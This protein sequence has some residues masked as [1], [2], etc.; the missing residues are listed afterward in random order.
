[1][2]RPSAL[3]LAFAVATLLIGC[4][5]KSE[6]QTKP[7]SAQSTVVAVTSQVALEITREL[8]G[9][10]FEVQKF[11]PD[12]TVSRLWTPESKDIKAIQKAGLIFLQGAGYDPWKDR[13]SLPGSRV[14]DVSKGIYDDFIRIPDAISHQHGPEG[15]HSHPG[16]VWATWLNPELVLPQISVIESALAKKNPDAANEISK[17]SAVLRS[18]VQSQIEKVQALKTSLNGTKVSLVADSSNYLYLAKAV[19]LEC[20]YLHG[21]E[22]GEFNEEQLQEFQTLLKDVPADGLRIFLIDAGR[23]ESAHSV[24][25]DAD[26][27]IVP[28]DTCE[29]AAI[30]SVWK[31]LA[32][33]IERL[34]AALKP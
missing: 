24:I 13:A 11:V 23:P 1:M 8:A 30:E 33:N 15:K 19:G 34:T 16:T 9:A 18:Q 28:I 3:P 7:T 5:Q 6:E 2:N 29:S 14:T 10:H 21:P 4:Q 17:A 31:R 20:R 22:S 27:R 25:K 26:F 12:S 32:G